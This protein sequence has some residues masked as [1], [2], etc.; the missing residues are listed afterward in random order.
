MLPVM[1]LSFFK[2]PK[3]YLAFVTSMLA[4]VWLAASIIALDDYTDKLGGRP[5]GSCDHMATVF[6]VSRK[7]IK[8]GL[9]KTL[10]AFTSIAL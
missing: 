10:I 9:K 4:V 5:Y 8:C 2:P 3:K 6:G 7:Y 1:I